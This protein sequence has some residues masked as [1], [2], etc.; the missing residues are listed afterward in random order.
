MDEEKQRKT[1]SLTHRQAGAGL[2]VIGAIALVAQLKGAFV[3][4]E[5]GDSVRDQLSEV[6]VAIVDLRGEVLSLIHI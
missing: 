3:T 1:I 5:E 4:R 6:K 2:G